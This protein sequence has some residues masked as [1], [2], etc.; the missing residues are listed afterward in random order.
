MLTCNIMRITI[1]P[2]LKKKN[3]K[4]KMSRNLKK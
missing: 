2:N 4:Q 1:K 3:P